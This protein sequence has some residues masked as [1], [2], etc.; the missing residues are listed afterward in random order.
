[1]DILDALAPLNHFCQLCNLTAWRISQHEH[2]LQRSRWLELYTW[3]VLGLASVY[4]TYGIFGEDVCST[5]SA[6]DAGY[7][8]DDIQ[9][10]GMRIAHAVALLETVW[11]RATKRDFYAEVQVIDRLFHDALNVSAENKKLRRLTTRRAAIMFCCYA[12]SQGFIMLTKILLST[13][14]FPVYWFCYLLPML[15]SGLRYFQIFTAVLIVRLR[16]ELMVRVLEKLRLRTQPTKSVDG[17]AHAVGLIAIRRLL[18]VR[19]LYEHLWRLVGL[20][21]RCYGLSMLFQ[22]GNDFLAITSN[23]YW[24]FLNFKKFTSSPVEFLQVVASTLW[25]APHLVNVLVLALM[26]ENASQYPTRLAVSLHRIQLDL[27]NDNHNALVTQFSLQLVHQRL[28]FSAAGF[29]TVD[30]TLL[31]T[32]VGAT[33]TYLIILIQFHMS[34]NFGS[35]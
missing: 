22:V 1:M 34:E 31:Y 23:C 8:M 28:T 27:E 14:E 15:V 25:S 11:K 26:C 33:T 17:D 2:R 13:P 7:T 4:T 18:V 19:Q 3:T 24:I 30:C 16:L 12:I 6:D 35:L 10:L 5:K 9:L 29:F 21:N 20:L 32:I